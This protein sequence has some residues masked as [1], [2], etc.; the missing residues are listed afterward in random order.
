MPLH[1]SQWLPLFLRVSTKVLIIVHKAFHDAPLSPIS[2]HVS[3]LSSPN[4]CIPDTLVSLLLCKYQTLD[5]SLLLRMHF[6]QIYLR[7]FELLVKW[8]LL[9][10]FFLAS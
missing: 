9:R 2:L 7:G 10:E 8:Y 4:H 6:L 5:N 3:L 1:I